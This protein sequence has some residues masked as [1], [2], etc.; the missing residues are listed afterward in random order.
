MDN[1]LISI[2]LPV[3]NGE[4]TIK[5]S[6]ESVLMQTYKHF[7]LII[8]NDGSLDN[9]E[10]I[11][12]QFDDPRIILINNENNKGLIKSLNIGLENSKGGFISRID[13]DDVW[14]CEDKLEEQLNFGLLQ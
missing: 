11:I 5:K 1:S 2:I 4:E 13:C 6:I 8:I 3:Y 10:K 14:V 12:E 7:E 9:T